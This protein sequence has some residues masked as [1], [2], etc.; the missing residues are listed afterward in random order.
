MSKLDA[1]PAPRKQRLDDHPTTLR[2]RARPPALA[3]PRLTVERVRALALDA[4]AHDAGVVS[5]EHPDLV[6]E[7]PYAKRALPGARSIISIVMRM[8]PDDVRSP[9]R[10]VA[11]LEFH[12][13]GHDVDVVAQKIAVALSAL[14]HRSINPAMAFPMEMDD[15]PGRTWV[16]SQKTVAV[17][18]QLGRIGLHRNV[19]H[20][21]FGSFVLLGAV[22]TEGDIEGAAAPLAFNPCVECKLCVAACP[23]GA[24]ESDGAF[25]F[26]GMLRP[27]LPRV[28]D[29]LR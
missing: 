10:S 21:V 11:N 20:P 17:A 7:R 13:A 19:I 9:A 25:R 3:A 6:G 27:Q 26:F 29:R 5:L 14:G 1:P 18:A 15:F 24:I 16:V 2:L 22:L 12:R 8:H 28:H 23:V 4:G